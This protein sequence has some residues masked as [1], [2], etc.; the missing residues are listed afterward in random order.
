[1]AHVYSHFINPV[2]V[3]QR[4]EHPRLQAGLASERKGRGIDEKGVHLPPNVTVKFYRSI[5]IIIVVVVVGIVTIILIIIVVVM[6]IVKGSEEENLGNMCE[7]TPWEVVLRQKP[8]RQI[9]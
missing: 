1:M 4:V 6:M 3:R 8:R 7:V 9:C 2:P 5:A